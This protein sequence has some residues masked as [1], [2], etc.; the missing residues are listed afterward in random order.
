MAYQ[1][2][3]ADGAD[4]V[5]SLLSNVLTSHGLSMCLARVSM[6]KTMV[7]GD[8]TAECVGN[9]P[10]AKC[11]LAGEAR[12]MRSTLNHRWFVAAAYMA[13]TATICL[14]PCKM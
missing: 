6:N 13:R 2:V 10:L 11:I 7:N 5:L 4:H 12:V 8:E 14:M 9:D 1:K 3:Y